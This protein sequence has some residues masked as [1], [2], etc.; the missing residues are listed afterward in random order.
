M[1]ILRF[2]SKDSSVTAHGHSQSLSLPVLRKLSA[3]HL[4]PPSPMPLS[5]KVFPL[6][7]PRLRR[8]ATFLA[9]VILVLFSLYMFFHHPFSALTTLKSGPPADVHRVLETLKAHQHNSKPYPTERREQV[10]LNQAQELAAVSS[11]IASLPHNVIPSYVNPELPID[12]QLIL[13]FDT[14]GPRAEQE[15][16]AMV[17]DVWTRN[18]VF[19]Y[20]KVSYQQL[21]VIKH[22][23]DEL[24]RCTRPLREKSKVH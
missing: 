9:L 13:D 10:H 8:R 15:V 11:F 7:P 22:I 20:S 23:D 18:P 1:S 24:F 5:S 4:P 2:S 12:P 6:R 14:R 3:P 21:L 17:A 19:L 16:Q